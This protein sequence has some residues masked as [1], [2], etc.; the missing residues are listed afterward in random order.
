MIYALDS[1]TVSYMLK[2]D[3]EVQRRFVEAIDKGH[4][5]AIVPLVYYEVKRGLIAKK[6]QPS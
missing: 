4:A 5:Y 1:N 6:R 3:I 2:G